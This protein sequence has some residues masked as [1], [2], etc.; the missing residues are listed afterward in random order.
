[1][2]EKLLLLANQPT[3]ATGLDRVFYRVWLVARHEAILTSINRSPRH[4]LKNVISCMTV[5]SSKTIDWVKTADELFSLIERKNLSFADRTESNK[6]SNRQEAV[7]RTFGVGK[8]FIM[9]LPDR[10]GFC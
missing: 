5:A 8:P 9:A 10:W 1:M 6:G 7:S 2:A 4:I 3:F